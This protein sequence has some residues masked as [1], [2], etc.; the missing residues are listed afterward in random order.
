V[1]HIHFSHRFSVLK[2]IT[3]GKV[4]RLLGRLNIYFQP[5]R[6]YCI[7]SGYH[8]A[9]TVEIFDDRFNS[10]Q[11][12]RGVYESALALLNEINGHSV[13]D[14]GCGSAYKLIDKFN[15]YDTVG[16]ELK[17]SYNWLL[18]KYPEKKWMDFER[19]IPSDLAADLVICSDVIE[20]VEN[21][22]DLMHFLK[23]MRFSR[24]MIS[25]P[26]RDSV[27][28]KN[29]FGPPE[30]TTHYREWNKEEF[31]DFVSKWFNVL[32]QEISRDKS[33]SQILICTTD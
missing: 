20:H 26:E 23:K 25:T 31:K 30:N 21:P 15:Y 28:G 14:V 16:I 11:W 12:Q 7:K 33:I 3:A 18:K 10:D 1:N 22:D 8:H 5:R 29:D 32:S 6:L 4:F 24:L 9:D 19:V 17:E 2:R 27:R 13:I